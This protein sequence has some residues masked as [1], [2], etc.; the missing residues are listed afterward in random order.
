MKETIYTIPINEA[1]SLDIECPFCHLEDNLEKKYLSAALGAALMEPDTRVDMNNRGFCKHHYESMFNSKENIL[2]L[3]LIMETFYKGQIGV[4]EKWGKNS[5]KIMDSVL[6]DCH[7]CN[8]MNFT[9]ERYFDNCIYMW[10]DELEFRKLFQSKK[11]FCI[12]HFLM[13]MERADAKLGK[14]D[15]ASF[16]DMLVK[17]QLEN[18]K[19]IDEELLW[20]AKKFDYRFKEEPWGDAKDSPERSIKKVIGNA[21]LEV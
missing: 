1:F 17:M 5:K 2:G 10:K 3:S 11:G 8:E 19:R 13:S 12:K 9:M 15:K 4:L 14:K 6:K 18:L 20:F 16:T 7:I 21:D